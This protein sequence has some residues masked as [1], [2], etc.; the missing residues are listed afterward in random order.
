MTEVFD[1]VDATPEAEKARIALQGPSGCGKTWTALRIAQGLGGEIGLIDTEHG[2]ASKYGRNFKFKTLKL[3]HYDPMNLVR[4]IA[5]ASE[6]G[7]GVLI[8]DSG[9]H[10]WSGKGGILAKVDEAARRM[11]GNTFGGWKD[12][13]PIEQTMLDAILSF[14]GH[15]II[16]L[17]VKT[18]WSIE[19]NERGKKVPV[20]IGLKPEQRDGLDY[21]FDVVG[22]LDLSHNLTVSKS[23]VVDVPVGEVVEMAGEEFGKRIA[24]WLGSGAELPNAND[25]RDRALDKNADRQALLDLYQE[26]QQRGL[27][28]AAVIDD[29][30][31]AVSLGALITKRG[32]QVARPAEAA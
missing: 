27:L 20:K 1:F 2:S 8:I 31:E 19:E 29:T 16:T 23:R 7:I 14:P 4:A 9:S 11:G 17:R 32:Q 26:V 5:R 15:V 13:R 21:E 30:D 6:R 18:E 25:Y 10:F 24:D 22:E 12:V 3:S 28:G